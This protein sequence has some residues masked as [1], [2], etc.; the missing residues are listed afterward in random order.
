[1][2]QCT[3]PIKLPENI[4]LSKGS[5]EF[6][7]YTWSDICVIL[8]SH[9]LYL[10][11]LHAFLVIFHVF[12]VIFYLFSLSVGSSELLPNLSQWLSALLQLTGVFS[13]VVQ[14]YLSLL[15]NIVWIM[16]LGLENTF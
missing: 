6:V 4:I 15:L 11:K 9:D 13:A 12:L 5:F 3:L 14:G 1:M 2:F 10:I 8:G 16:Q 7:H